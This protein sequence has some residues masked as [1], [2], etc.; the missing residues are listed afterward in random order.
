MKYMKQLTIILTIS[1]IGDMMNKFIPLPVPAGVYGMVLLFV[2]LCTKALKLDQVKET[3][4][5]LIE[6][7]PITFIP[8]GVGLMASWGIIEPILVPVVTITV[9]STIAVM[10]VGAR[11]TQ[12]IL[13]LKKK[14]GK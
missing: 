9:V 12:R 4:K 2:L 11:V 6:I 14:G 10:A 7:M 1:F 13:R 8:P 3:G 5:F